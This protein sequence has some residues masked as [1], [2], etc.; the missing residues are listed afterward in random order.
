MKSIN[1]I[2]YSGL[3]SCITTKNRL[4]RSKSRESNLNES[5][6]N[7]SCLNNYDNHCSNLKENNIKPNP[8]NKSIKIS[9]V[10]TRKSS[11]NWKNNDDDDESSESHTNFDNL[12]NPNTNFN[13]SNNLNKTNISF[14][15][16]NLIKNENARFKKKIRSISR[17][18]PGE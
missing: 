17:I 13:L 11:Q 14:Y 10:F 9:N 5:K 3:Y 18:N 12:N 16:S 15:Q 6:Y 8:Y 2:N 7:W 4:S 1:A